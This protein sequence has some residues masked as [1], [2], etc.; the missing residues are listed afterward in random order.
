MI[1]TCVKIHDRDGSDS[2]FVEI[3]L[4][5]VNYI[6][7]WQPTRSKEYCPAYHTSTGSYIGLRTLKDISKAYAKYGFK[8]YDRSTVVNENLI[9]RTETDN[10]G[11]KVFFDDGSFV[12]IRT[13]L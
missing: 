8:S 4:Y 1:V 9:K 6:D 7:L 2:D 3:S 11:S 12:L 13:K 10:H 5:D